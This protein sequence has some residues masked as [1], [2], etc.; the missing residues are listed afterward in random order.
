[1]L[2]LRGA[3]LIDGRGGDPVRS[4]VVS[5]DGERI[6]R[7]DRGEPAKGASVV[8][9]D[10]LTLLPGLIDAHVHLGLSSDLDRFTAGR[11]SLAEVAARIFKTCGETL[12]AGFTTVRDCGG[13]DGGL[14]GA[15]D[16]GL[17]R[18]PRVI[19]A[20]PIIC[21]TGG[22]GHW[23]APT[24]EADSIGSPDHVGLTYG[25][26]AAD[27]PDQ[28]RH[29]VREA[30]RRGA[31][32][33]KLCVS[34]GVVSHSDS[35]EDT[36]LTCDEIRAAVVEAMARHTYVTVHS[37]NADGIRNAVGAGV[38]CI[39]HGT[40]MDE[41]TAALMA[42]EEVSHV[43]TL[44]VVRLLETN[45]ADMGLTK[46]IGDRVAGVRSALGNAIRMSK[47]AGVLVGAGSDLIGPLQ[48][49]RGLELKLRAEITDP[50]E[51][52]GASTAANARILGLYDELG[53]V[54][55]GKRADLIAVRG[56]PLA[57]PGLFDDPSK[58]ALVVK[59]G[60]IVKNLVA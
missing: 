5:I 56:D 25:S 16:A 23:V 47:A 2:A 53:T 4:S 3:T 37:H 42:R 48:N 28:V 14:V 12:D 52:I 10:G 46:A 19:F 60:A 33:I 41:E 6:S 39:E 36:Q 22:H 40:F 27:G 44:A 29:E 30:F 26:R 45:Y 54:E 51:A 15:I 17:V 13:V 38:R 31:S 9:L 57:D 1:M 58:V 35:L 18:G 50:L 20:G 59:N 7:V 55:V 34:G 11:V 32:F 43:P 24:A 49:R 8:D 21:Q